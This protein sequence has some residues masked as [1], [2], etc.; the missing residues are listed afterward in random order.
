MD[1]LSGDGFLFFKT[2]SKAV[3]Y[4]LWLY[5]EI[6]QSISR[7]T[8]RLPPRPLLFVLAVEVLALEIRQDKLCRGIKLPHKH[9]AKLSQFADDT[10]LIVRDL[11]SLRKAVETMSIF[12][13]ISGLELN[14]KKAKVMGFGSLKNN[15]N[16]PLSERSNK[17]LG[18]ASLLRS[19]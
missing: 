14:K 18:N 17:V 4:E 5:D 19:I 15:S 11:D 2:M 10:T 9:E 13:S 1:L 16:K 3:L 6:L 12:G 8:P 7:R